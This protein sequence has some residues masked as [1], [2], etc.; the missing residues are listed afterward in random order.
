MAKKKLSKSHKNKISLSLDRRKK[1]K[2]V[3]KPG[4][5]RKSGDLKGKRV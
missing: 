5:P 2:K 3:R 4:Q 1:A